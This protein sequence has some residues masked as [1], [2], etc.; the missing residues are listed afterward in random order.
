MKISANSVCFPSALGLSVPKNSK[1]PTGRVDKKW[2]AWLAAQL[3]FW[4]KVGEKAPTKAD[5]AGHRTVTLLKTQQLGAAWLSDVTAGG[6]LTQQN[7][8]PTGS[9][10]SA[11][12]FLF[13]F[14]RLCRFESYRARD[15]FPNNINKP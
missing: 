14:A 4:E 6:A 13:V 1:G 9:S 7:T 8:T 12:L 15:R 11:G 5:D 10:T 3:T 2:A